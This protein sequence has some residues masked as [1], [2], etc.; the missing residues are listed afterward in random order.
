MGICLELSAAGLILLFGYI[1]WPP[2]C[3]LLLAAF[4]FAAAWAND[5]DETV[6]ASNDE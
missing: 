2:A 4:L 5:D 3:L 6:K 1:V